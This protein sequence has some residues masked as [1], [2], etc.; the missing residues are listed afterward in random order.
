MTIIL[1][2]IA[3]RTAW[4]HRV[5]PDRISRIIGD[6]E[7]G[8]SGQRRVIG[9]H[10]VDNRY[11]DG[12][13][14]EEEEEEGAEQDVAP[15]RAIGEGPQNVKNNILTSGSSEHEIDPRLRTEDVWNS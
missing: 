12:I 8:D 1:C 7:G 5:L 15:R 4:I 11:T 10:A 2:S 9:Y 14:T 13:I 6:E 3:P